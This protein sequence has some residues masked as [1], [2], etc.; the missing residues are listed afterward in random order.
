VVRDH[1]V[2]H[3]ERVYMDLEQRVVMLGL[4]IIALS[5]AAILIVTLIR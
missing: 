1:R 2:L 3:S 4:L 5:S